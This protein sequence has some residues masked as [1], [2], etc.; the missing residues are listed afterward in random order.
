MISQAAIKAS[1]SLCSLCLI[2]G[3][4]LEA[5]FFGTNSLILNERSGLFFKEASHW[6][7]KFSKIYFW[8]KLVVLVYKTAIHYIPL[9]C[10]QVTFSKSMGVKYPLIFSNY[11]L[12]L[13]YQ[14]CQF[15]TKVIS[16]TNW[17]NSLNLAICPKFE[18]FTII[19]PRRFFEDIDGMV[20]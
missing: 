10:T 18:S 6:N 5:G 4:R 19:C 2:R 12:S 9:N 14:V 17:E 13:G 8:L 7:G 11:S 1:I 16:D 15:S 3:W 20:S